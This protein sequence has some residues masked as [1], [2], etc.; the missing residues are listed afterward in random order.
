MSRLALSESDI[1]RIVELVASR[2]VDRVA[3]QLEAR[4]PKQPIA[5]LTTPKPG[6]L[7][8]ENILREQA[9]ALSL[10]ERWHQTHGGEAVQ[11]RELY[12]LADSLSE[13]V[14]N[15]LDRRGR[16]NALG[17]FVS[18]MCR[19]EIPGYRVQLVGRPKNRAHYRIQKIGGSH[20]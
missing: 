2:V 1:E 5:N 11:T 19:M 10:A 15:A 8:H 3:D 14:V 9:L 13:F 6:T 4:K 12:P 16:I 7:A 18:R 17:Q 20:E